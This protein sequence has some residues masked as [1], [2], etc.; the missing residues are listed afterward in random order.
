MGVSKIEQLIEDIFDFVE[1]SKT[2]FANPNKVTLH[3]DELY[4][5]LDELR[6]RTPEEIKKYQ[7]IIANRDKI[8][9]D[10]KNNA[11]LMI[12]QANNRAAALIDESEMVHQ[13]NVKAE[14]IVN[15]AIA[16][17]KQIVAEA[18]NDATQIRT[19]ALVYTNDLLT[20]AESILQN[21]YKNTK[22]RYDLVF[23]ALKEDLDIIE[24]NKKEIERD[25][26]HEVMS[27]LSDNTV[28]DLLEALGEADIDE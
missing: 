16:D 22:S 1:N 17:A 5:M 25:L 3:R 7:K 23:E 4:D 14:D 6:M 21:A 27:D 2:S 19:G 26:P 11:D 15:S 10:A 20:N 18:N 24:A 13:A 8:L 9:V 12:E 28:D